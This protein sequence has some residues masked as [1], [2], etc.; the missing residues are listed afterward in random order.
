MLL[1]KC[2]V[3]QYCSICVAAMTCATGAIAEDFD[4]PTLAE[5][6][7]PSILVLVTTDKQGKPLALGSGFLLSEDGLVATNYHVIKG[8]DKFIAKSATGQV[9]NILGKLAI[10]PDHDLAILKIDAHRLPFLKLGS[11]LSV[12]AGSKIAVIGSPLGLEGSLSDGIVSA[13]RE[14]K[15][16]SRLLQITVVGLA[17]AGIGVVADRQAKT[18]A[19]IGDELDQTGLFGR[20]VVRI[21][22]VAQHY[23]RIWG[24]APGRDLRPERRRSVAA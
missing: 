10:D 1:D 22:P 6:V 7:R 21:T 5:E 15:D 19:T 18:R 14:I 20:A 17:A 8:A 12:R 9:F 23:K 4:L 2:L 11:S 24:D 13:I 3:R 16:Q